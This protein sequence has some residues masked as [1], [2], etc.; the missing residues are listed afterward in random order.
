MG[1]SDCSIEM[2]NGAR[3]FLEIAESLRRAQRCR[4]RSVGRSTRRR[5]GRSTCP[6]TAPAA[7]GTPAAAWPA[8]TSASNSVPAPLP[9]PTSSRAA[10][11]PAAAAPR[12]A[13]AS[14]QVIPL[15]LLIPALAD[16]HPASPLPCRARLLTG[17]HACAACCCHRTQLS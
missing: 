14:L 13:P 8:T 1:V 10:S 12:P 2:A 9:A 5:S 3:P 7:A 11:A 15:A 4:W 16:C 6:A 17:I